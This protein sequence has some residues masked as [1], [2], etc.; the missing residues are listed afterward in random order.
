[1]RTYNKTISREE[2]TFLHF[3]S[4]SP[5]VAIDSAVCIN[6]QASRTF[7]S[8]SVCLRTIFCGASGVYEARVSV[9][10]IARTLTNQDSLA[11]DHTVA[12][13]ALE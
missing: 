9:Q 13:L 7:A 11:K 4:Y 1:M 6:Y 5:M 8:V 12:A 2:L 3:A 10:I